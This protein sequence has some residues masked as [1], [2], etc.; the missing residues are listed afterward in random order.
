MLKNRSEV[1]L[2]VYHLRDVA[3]QMVRAVPSGGPAR[4]RGVRPRRLVPRPGRGAGRVLGRR[5]PGRL[6]RGRVRVRGS[7]RR[8]RRRRPGRVRFPGHA[9]AVRRRVH[10]GRRP[11]DRGDL[12]ERPRRVRPVRDRRGRVVG[13]GA[14][15]A[16]RRAAQPLVAHGRVLLSTAVRVPDH[17]DIHARRPKPA[18]LRAGRDGWS[19]AA[20]QTQ[21]LPSRVPRGQNRSV[22]LAL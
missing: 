11:E 16:V 10:R 18:V 13:R 19:A 20:T 5:H 2:H 7:R 12:V 4:A 22:Q 8:R 21:F 1:Y 17:V 3:V 14:A 9:A 15:A 6:H